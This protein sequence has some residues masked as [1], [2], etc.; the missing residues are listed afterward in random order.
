[1]ELKD[2]TS[3]QIQGLVDIAIRN[4]MRDKITW[5]CYYPALLAHVKNYDPTMRLGLLTETISSTTIAN[6]QGLKTDKND[7]LIA[8]NISNMTSETIGLCI[9]ARIPLEAFL[10]N[11]SGAIRN[12][13]PYI[14]GA[15]SD[16]FIAGYELIVPNI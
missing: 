5:I 3:E 13:N 15:L 10:M 2:G 12:M 8:A 1:V 4:G 7:V 14:N 11:S 9:S 6:A 16:Y